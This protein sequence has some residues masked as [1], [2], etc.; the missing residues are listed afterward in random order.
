MDEKCCGGMPQNELHMMQLCTAFRW[1]SV[2]L[3]R[4]VFFP[5]LSHTFVSLCVTNN[6]IPENKDICISSE[7]PLKQLHLYVLRSDQPDFNTCIM[8]LQTHLRR[9]KM[10]S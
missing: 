7:F 9:L 4:T 8:H 6:L 3:S 5:L 2:I 1:L 10:K